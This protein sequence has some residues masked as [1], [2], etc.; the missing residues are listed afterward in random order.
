MPPEPRV[1]P[2]PWTVEPEQP[3]HAAPELQAPSG[4][5]SAMGQ[6]AELNAAAS[7]QRA[8]VPRTSGA[9]TTAGMAISEAVDVGDAAS[10]EVAA[11]DPA[12][13]EAQAKARAEIEALDKDMAGLFSSWQTG[14][15]SVIAKL[16]A[17]LE[18]EVAIATEVVPAGIQLAQHAVVLLGAALAGGVAGI[19]AHFLTTGARLVAGQSAA[20]VIGTAINQQIQGSEPATLFNGKVALIEF[21]EHTIGPAEAC[22]LGMQSWYNRAYA[23]SAKA[24]PDAA[25]GAELMGEMASFLR[26]GVGAFK[27]DV[28]FAG[29]D[30][31]A[32]AKA[33]Q[34]SASKQAAGP[35]AVPS[36]PKDAEADPHLADIERPEGTV[37]ILMALGA[38]GEPIQNFSISLPGASQAFK[39][40]FGKRLLHQVNAPVRLVANSGF[41]QNPGCVEGPQRDDLATRLTEQAISAFI[42][43]RSPVA[44]SAGSL[45]AQDTSQMT[46]AL[47]NANASAERWLAAHG[48]HGL[49]ISQPTP[50]QVDAGMR[51]LFSELDGV[52][53]P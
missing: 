22:V 20:A 40:R 47:G 16:S 25:K 5:A 33:G 41:F 51:Q 24:H 4:M 10:T 12:V 38:P 11:V 44:N 30:A 8:A 23:P 14:L 35:T 18:G 6:S 49:P 7:L 43:A 26:T 19:A 31:F 34:K 48:N 50:A 9:A 21:A 32:T 37:E 13:E 3:G 53:L 15:P 42:V 28:L 29:L 45:D 2:Q 17:I 52:V 27:R 1:V 46:L 36:G 39:Q